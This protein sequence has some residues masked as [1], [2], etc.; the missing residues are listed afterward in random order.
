M[1]VLDQR[2]FSILS[3]ETLYSLTG[4]LIVNSEGYCHQRTW[5]GLAG[6]IGFSTQGHLDLLLKYLHGDK[7][8]LVLAV[9]DKLEKNGATVKKLIIALK[10]LDV[11]NC[12]KDLEED[13][14]ITGKK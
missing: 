4:H 3:Q 10:S 11:V 6:R 14:S 8:F 2:V 7:G 9:W 12:I 1:N 13:T 5:K